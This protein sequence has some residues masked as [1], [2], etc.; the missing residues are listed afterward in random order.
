M[1]GNSVTVL[2]ILEEPEK[3]PKELTDVVKKL[4]IIITGLK[5]SHMNEDG[6]KVD[7]SSMGQSDEFREY[8]NIA[9]RLQYLEPENFSEDKRK[10]LFLNIYNCLTIHAMVHQ[11]AS[12]SIP[13]SPMKVPGFWKIHAYNIG[14]C[15]YNLD[16]IEHGVLRANKGHPNAGKPEF[17]E[18]DPRL[19]VSLTE[20]DP[21]IHFA[22]NCGAKSCPPIRVYTE[23][24]IEQQLQTAAQSFLDQEV[25][26]KELEDKS[27]DVE[28]SKLL[29]WYQADF[30]PSPA[31]LLHWV[32]RHR[33]DKIAVEQVISAGFSLKF[34]Q[35]DWASNLLGD[36]K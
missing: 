11:S 1:D 19:R 35:Y 10:A 14:G 8:C 15:V 23:E 34:Q 31:D 17:Q 7:Y 12:G 36:K 18:S 21:R 13:E 33:S 28:L 22:L 27:F 9:A 16:E 32:A 26:F 29:L 6:S 25:L 3:N 20:L 2:N 4:R 30:G 5:G 24:R